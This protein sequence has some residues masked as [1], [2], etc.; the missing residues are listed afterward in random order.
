VAAKEYGTPF[1][2]ISILVM[3][4]FYNLWLSG[5]WGTRPALVRFLDIVLIVAVILWTLAF[6]LKRAR[7]LVA[8]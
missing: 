4:V 2:W 1:G 3:M 7:I 6:S 5:Q 8:D